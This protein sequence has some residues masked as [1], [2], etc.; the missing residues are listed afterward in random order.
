MNK[1]LATILATALALLPAQP[2]IAANQYFG[3]SY[4][5]AGTGKAT[6]RV[7]GAF[8]VAESK[9]AY[10]TKKFE[11]DADYGLWTS[12]TFTL[13]GGSMTVKGLVAIEDGTTSS[14]HLG[15][16]TTAPVD[17]LHVVDD[18]SAALRLTDSSNGVTASDGTRLW[19]NNADTF[20]WNYETGNMYI[21]VDGGTDMTIL[22]G[23]DVGIG[24]GA[25]VSAKLHV[26]DGMTAEIIATV[27]AGTKATMKGTATT[28]QFGSVSNTPVKII[29][30]D[31]TAMHIDGS[32]NVGIGTAAPVNQLDVEGAVAI[33]VAYSGTSV[34]PTN[35]LIVE[36]NVGIGTTSPAT[37]LEVGG[38]TS[39]LLQVDDGAVTIN[40]DGG[41]VD[42]RVE[43]V[44]E[45]N[46][47]FVRG[48]KGFV[49]VGIDDPDVP[50]EVEVLLGNSWAAK[51]SNDSIN[52]DG[53]RIAAGHD[54]STEWILQ[55]LDK[56]DNSR[57]VVQYDGK[58]GIGTTEPAQDLHISQAAATTS[59]LGV[60]SATSAFCGI[61]G[62][63]DEAGCTECGTLNG[64]WD[65]G[66]DSDC[67]CDGG[68]D[69]D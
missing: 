55:L 6:Q 33:G 58:V 47:L 56:S 61:F 18:V 16:G 21:G 41:D 37:K 27:G 12:N 28:V 46:G 10:T 3:L 64:V 19:A 65:C 42:F 44:G 45:A 22:T 13:T 38:A 31:G 36:G 7:S 20:L 14:G 52:G 1:T 9:D 51:I 60:G 68:F 11:Y 35:G 43:G 25:N 2:A 32:K 62:D 8:Y 66:I 50:F 69:D 4:T 49:G 30:N 39:S 23:G 15:I 24:T 17:E 57:M 63:S 48:D 40:Q 53:L 67:T 54:S 34:A 5:S 26:N 59:K 29:Q